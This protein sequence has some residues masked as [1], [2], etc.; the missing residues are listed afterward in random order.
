MTLRVE[1]KIS[2]SWYLVGLSN[3]TPKMS[4]ITEME[5]VY[6]YRQRRR[7]SS[8]TG[9]RTLDPLLGPPSALAEFFRHM[10]L[11]G[12]GSRSIF[13]P[14]SYFFC[15]LK[16]CAKFHNL[17]TTPSGKKVCGGEKKRKER[18]KNNHK[19]SGHFVPLQCL[20]AAHTL[21]SDQFPLTFH[22]L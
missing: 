4:S 12:G 7:G 10:C 20:K 22:S 14:R 2:F 15:D 5:N 19:N 17:R 18:K 16:L 1:L 6:K 11:R 3:L 9:L 21:R 8:L 13:Y